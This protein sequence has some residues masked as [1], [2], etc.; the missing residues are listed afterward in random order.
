[1][2]VTEGLAAQDVEDV[3]V[4]IRVVPPLDSANN[5]SIPRGL[6]GLH[7]SAL[8]VPNPVIESTTAME[9]S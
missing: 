5:R 4:A 7:F 8:D 1:M 3:G 9:E 2:S 6:A